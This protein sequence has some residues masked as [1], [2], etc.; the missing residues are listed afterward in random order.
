MQKEMVKV[1]D[2]TSVGRL[3]DEYAMYQLAFLQSQQSKAEP[4]LTAELAI[5]HNYIR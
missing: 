2:V 1:A 3:A 5:R 4:E